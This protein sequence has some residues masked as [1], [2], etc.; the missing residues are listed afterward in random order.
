MRFFI[1]EKPPVAVVNEALLFRVIRGSFQMRRK[2]LFNTLGATLELPKDRIE[3]L[4]RHAR[5]DPRRRGETLTL[6]ECR[7]LLEAAHVEQPGR[8][9]VAAVDIGHP[10]HRDED[11]ATAE[12]LGD[13]AEHTR[14]G[15]HQDAVDR[16]VVREPNDRLLE[17]RHPVEVITV[18]E[19]HDVAPVHREEPQPALERG[20]DD[21]LGRGRNSLLF[22][23][24]RDGDPDLL[25]A[26][27][28]GRF[29]ALPS[30]DRFYRND[31]GTFV[32]APEGR[33]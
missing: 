20:L 9:D 29:D 1:R 27:E 6:E 8:V 15:E 25:V 17:R 32:A 12:H 10:G 24:D 14:L 16:R 31:G 4:C 18:A 19:R 28:P 22:D 30:I 11:P 23:A 21:P 3:R 5:V 26:N 33:G 7:A 2:Q 13:H